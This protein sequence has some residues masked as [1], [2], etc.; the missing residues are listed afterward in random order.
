MGD[1]SE[2]RGGIQQDPVAFPPDA[3]DGQVSW[4]RFAVEADY[5][6]SMLRS[7]LGD[8]EACVGALRRS[9]DADPTFPATVLALGSVEYQLG[10]HEEGR[11]L[12]MA[13]PDLDDEDDDLH[14]VLDLA[15]DFL[16]DIQ[17]YGDGLLLYRRAVARFPAVPVLHQGRGCCAG[18][19]GQHEEAIEASRVALSLEPDNQQYVNDLG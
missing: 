12:L 11:R 7:A 6:D 14:E 3:D 19:E 16:I 5:A 15:G 9:F 1:R 10:N 8:Q 17:A 4:S 2:Q 18:H 13:L